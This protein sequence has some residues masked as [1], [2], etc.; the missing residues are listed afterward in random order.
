MNRC[1]ILSALVFLFLAGNHV[2]A[3]STSPSHVAGVV[4]LNTATKEQLLMLPYI[5]ENMADNLIA[6]RNSSGPFTSLNDLLREKARINEP[7][8]PLIIPDL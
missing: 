5:N 2:Q 1:V 6:Y 7:V 4:N 3:A 8:L